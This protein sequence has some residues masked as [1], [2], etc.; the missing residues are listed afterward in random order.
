MANLLNV[1]E[2]IRSSIARNSLASEVSNALD[3]LFTI[4]FLKRPF[5]NR[6]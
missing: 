2:E 4:E 1:K 3:G 5:A 6:G